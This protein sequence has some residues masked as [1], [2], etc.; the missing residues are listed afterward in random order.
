M[1]LTTLSKSCNLIDFIIKE[2]R[3]RKEITFTNINA[4]VRLFLKDTNELFNIFHMLIGSIIKYNNVIC[5]TYIRNK[6]V[7]SYMVIHGRI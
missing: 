5:K 4:Q 7:S 3:G 1:L 6:K 2:E